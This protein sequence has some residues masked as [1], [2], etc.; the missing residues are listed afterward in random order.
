MLDSTLSDSWC[1][2][3]TRS[4][5][6]LKPVQVSSTVYSAH[7]STARQR[8]CEVYVRG[9]TRPS[10]SLPTTTIPYLPCKILYIAH[11]VIMAVSTLT[12]VSFD[13]TSPPNM[14]LS[15]APRVD[16]DIDMDL[17]LGSVEDLTAMEAEAMKIVCHFRSRTRASWIHASQNARLTVHC[18]D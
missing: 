14:Q 2:A 17:E 8:A 1:S 6:T 16:M 15:A 9:T 10:L 7:P 12:P 4:E 13:L 18:L 3:Q 11:A 5:R